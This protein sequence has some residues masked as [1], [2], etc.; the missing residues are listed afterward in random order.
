MY[1]A[2]LPDDDPELLRAR[3]ELLKTWPEEATWKYHGT[4][5]GGPTGYRHHYT[6]D[7]YPG[8]P[9]DTGV[10]ADP[11]WTPPNK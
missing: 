8:R 7:D 3:E 4:R 6:A 2:K 11:D 9:V 1:V 10:P 5:K